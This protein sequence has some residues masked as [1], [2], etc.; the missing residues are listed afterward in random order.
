MKLLICTHLVMQ[1]ILHILENKYNKHSGSMFMLPTEK[2]NYFYK[3]RSN[4]NLLVRPPNWFDKSLNIE[5]LWNL[6]TFN[7]AAD[8][9]YKD[10]T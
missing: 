3:L 9:G 2:M 8:K 5:W 10:N 1:N 7:W 4:L 6:L